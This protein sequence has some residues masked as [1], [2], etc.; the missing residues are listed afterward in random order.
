MEPS[1]AGLEALLGTLN[2]RG[3]EPAEPAAEITPMNSLEATVPSIPVAVG[4]EA[5]PRRHEAL[6][7]RRGASRG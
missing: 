4:L 7:P 6:C 2:G 5:F 1:D 3:F